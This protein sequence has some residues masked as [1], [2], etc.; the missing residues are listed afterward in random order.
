MS[1]KIGYECKMYYGA[2]ALTS[3]QTAVNGSYTELDAAKDVSLPLDKAEADMTTR[4]NAGWKATRGGLKDGSLDFEMLWDPE[5]AG[6]QKIKAAFL[7]N[8]TVLLAIMDGSIAVSD[9]E[10]F[11]ANFEIMSFPVNQPLEEGVTIAV[12]AKPRDHHEWYVVA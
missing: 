5:D 8:T 2:A 10:G 12:T 3:G 9:N 4:A 7:A 1:D 6:V 11:V